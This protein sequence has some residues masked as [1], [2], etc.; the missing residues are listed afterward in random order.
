MSKK[1][2]DNPFFG[3]LG[4]LLVPAIVFCVVIS[5]DSLNNTV[6][7]TTKETQV[8]VE[9]ESKSRELISTESIS[10]TDSEILFES[11]KEI[12]SKTSIELDNPD[13]TQVESIDPS[14][15]TPIEIPIETPIE[16][17]NSAI[18]TAVDVP[19]YTGADEVILNGG[20]STFTAAELKYDGV[21]WAV[22]G[23]LD[24]WNRVT[25][26]DA[27]VT[28]NMYDTGTDADSRILPTGWKKSEQNAGNPEQLNRGH[29]LADVLG[30]SGEDWRNLVTLYRNANYPTMYF[31]AEDIVKEAI[32]HG[33][34]VRYR[35]TPIFIGEELMCEGMHIM[36][37]SVTDNSVDLNVYVFNQPKDGVN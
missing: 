35:V 37:K 22:Y 14:L 7:N 11:I 32:Q 20:N 4:L 29:L 3:M 30:G 2:G 18:L 13:F 36:A 31:A 5:N 12:E 26:M 6:E 16:Q 17:V 1:G 15:E 23:N 19:T 8:I 24:D 28:P 33:S 9:T 34:V 25:T 21:G 10:S 27:M